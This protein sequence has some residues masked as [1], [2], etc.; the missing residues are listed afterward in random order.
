M[1][2]AGRYA[3]RVIFPEANRRHAWE[4]FRIRRSLPAWAHPPL[5]RKAPPV[6]SAR[7]LAF[8]LLFP[9]ILLHAQTRPR[10]PGSVAA[11]A[12]TATPLPITRVSLYKN[13]VGFFEHAGRVTGSQS[14]TI[15]F[16]TAQLNDVL[17]SLTAIDLGGGRIA[18]A[19]YNSTTPF[20]QQLKSLPLALG[21]DAD[22][23]A[24]YNAIRGAR[25]ELHAPG[26]AITGRLLSIES[27]TVPVNDD[28]A[29][30]PAEKRFLTVVSDTGT[31]RTVELTPATEVR[32]LD[33]ALHTDV[34]RYLELLAGT[35]SNGLRHLTLQDNGEGT[36]D[37]RVSYISE[38]PIWK[39]TYRILF[40]VRR[41]PLLRNKPPPCKAGPSS[42]TPPA[43]TG[44]TSSS[45]SSP[46]P[47]RASS[48]PSPPPTTPAAPRF[49]CP[50][51]PSSP[52]RRMTRA[53]T[54]TEP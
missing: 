34:S 1:R 6:P 29:G 31:V 51:R 21:E 54:R 50:K 42:T 25:V 4:P 49:P 14:V 7:P 40:T 35:R 16:T 46:E 3:V 12:Q 27:R 39:S 5:Q 44:S 47:R 13:G 19:G 53:R 33:T 15:D 52:R 36:R 2:V 41:R 10:N 26:V 17:Q 28:A 9:V 11:T 48:N 38:V 8:L 20:E 18:G 24:F 45:R 30:P 22:S 23:T 37:L 43:P 32:L